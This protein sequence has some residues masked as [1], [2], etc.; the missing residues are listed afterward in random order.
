MR[1]LF[2]D[3]LCHGPFRPHIHTQIA[4]E[5]VTQE[6]EV[7]NEERLIQAHQSLEFGAHLRCCT[8]PKCDASG[9]A[10]HHVDGRQQQQHRHTDDENGKPEAFE[11]VEQHG[12]LSG[13]GSPAK[14]T[15]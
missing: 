2:T 8:G 15:S 9:V 12:A 4:S 7:L 6:L 3:H 14:S 1:E 13:D 11:S 10:W 5:H